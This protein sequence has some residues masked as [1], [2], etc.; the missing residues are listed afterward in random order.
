MKF[1]QVQFLGARGAFR[2]VPIS[3]AGKGRNTKTQSSTPDL[4]EAERVLKSYKENNPKKEWRIAT[5]IESNDFRKITKGTPVLVDFG[6]AKPVAFTMGGRKRHDHKDGGITVNAKIDLANGDRYF[7]LIELDETS[8]GEHC[9]T[10]ILVPEIDPVTGDAVDYK[11]I[12]LHDAPR[13]A[14]VGLTGADVFPYRYN[15]RPV[16]IRCSDHHVDEA[17]GWSAP[18]PWPPASMSVDDSDLAQDTR[19]GSRRMN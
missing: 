1:Y 3:Q 18:D 9:G 5:I 13:R 6:D 12:D 17:T 2:P 4:A 10:L 7:G 11:L 15:Y 14:E 19:N 8:S 16:S